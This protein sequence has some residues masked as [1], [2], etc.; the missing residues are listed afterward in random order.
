VSG[1]DPLKSIRQLAAGLGSEGWFCRCGSAL[2]A[3]ERREAEGYL[4]GLGLPGVPIEGVAGWE[5][6]SAITQRADW[7]REWWDA[8]AREAERLKAEAI[9]RLGE[10][11]LLEALSVVTESAIG[12]YGLAAA[13]AARAGVEDTGL[14]RAAAGAA[15]MAAHQMGLALAAEAGIDHPLACKYRLFSGGRWLLGVIGGRCYLF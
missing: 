9:P 6:A 10:V 13:A 11:P 7:S 1:S 12:L 2:N 14:I 3:S 5:L 8:E 15:A 4:V